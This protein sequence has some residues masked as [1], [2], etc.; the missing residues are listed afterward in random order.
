ML[1]ALVVSQTTAF[2]QDSASRPAIPTP[3]RQT[4]I[5][6]LL[7]ETL[8]LSK[9]KSK[10]DKEDAVTKLMELVDQSSDSPDEL[11][12]TLNTAIPLLRETGDLD[13]HQIAVQKLTE[14]FSADPLKEQTQ[15]L[16]GF[17]AACKS[18]ESLVPAVE[19]LAGLAVDAGQTNEFDQPLA[20]LVAADKVAKKLKDNTSVA[21]MANT[22]VRLTQR[23]GAFQA[24]QAAAQTLVTNAV[25][26]KANFTEG[27]WL[28][29]YEDNWDSALQLLAK[30]SDAQWKA[31]AT[32]QLAASEDAESQLKAA[33]A[34]WEVAQTAGPGQVLV[35]QR[36]L[37]LYTKALPNVPSALTRAKVT[38]RIQELTAKLTPK[39]ED[40]PVVKKPAAK[41]KAKKD[42]NYLPVGEP[43]DLLA[44]VKLPE[45]AIMGRWERD[46]DVLICEPGPASRCM[47]PVCVSGNYE[48]RL[49]FT[50]HSNNEAIH[51]SLPVG[52]TS[53]EFIVDGWGGQITGLHLVDGKLAVD[54]IGIGGIRT[55]NPVANGVTHELNIDV[56]HQDESVVIDA[57]L[58]GV[59]VFSW[60]GSPARLSQ[61]NGGVMPIGQCLKLRVHE[62]R[63][64]FHRF[65][66]ELNKRGRGYRLGDDWKNPLFPV[67]DKP[68]REVA[69]ALQLLDWNGKRYFISDKPMSLP[70]VQHLATQ[71]KGRLVT[72]SSREEQD[73]LAS[74]TLGSRHYWTA[75][76]CAVDRIWR[77]ERNRKLRYL[78]WDGSEPT[79]HFGRENWIVMI[80]S[81]VLQ[82]YPTYHGWPHACIEWGEEYPEEP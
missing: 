52:D 55:R 2:S 75:G 64:T 9:L 70:D 7:D 29:I 76:W 47:V 4:E 33:D 6:A 80:P 81:G 61:W 8:G 57:M 23:Q 41:A 59:S 1:T 11:Y 71:V 18:R 82:D 13:T 66:L 46:G 73:F 40:A 44:M 74:T 32:A 25:D 65:E 77:D 19:E 68:S 16:L 54:N 20:W 49:R 15:L 3:E 37:D 42:D 53:C 30:G 5:L 22:R 48:L 35:Q 17:I 56:A 60:S 26:P 45:H 43:I 58:D 72:I 27:Q 79:N 62:S 34:W 36:A 31:A 51:V 67:D 10:A 78:N 63:V 21:L 14:T 28:A 24:H 12:V 69:K 39:A 50:R 38:K